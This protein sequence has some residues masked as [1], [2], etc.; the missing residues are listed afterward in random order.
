MGE[1]GAHIDQDEAKSVCLF[2]V[3]STHLFQRRTFGHGTRDPG[4][5]ARHHYIGR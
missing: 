4:S 5:Q 3:R 2:Q 1:E